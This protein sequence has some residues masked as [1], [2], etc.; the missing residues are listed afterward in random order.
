MSETRKDKTWTR[1]EVEAGVV[2]A[3]IEEGMVDAERVTPDAT[4]ESLEIESVEFVMILDG[5]E[6]RF[7]LYIPV[8]QGVTDITTVSD[9]IDEIYR[10]VSGTNDAAE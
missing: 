4:I 1:L 10:R 6:R 7:D 8:D 2:A 5:L 9:L 3:I